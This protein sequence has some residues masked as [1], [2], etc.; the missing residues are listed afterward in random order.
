[1]AGMRTAAALAVLVAGSLL[2]RTGTLHAGYWIDEGIAVGIA[3]HDLADIPRT[4]RLDGSPPL[5]YLLLHGWMQL[6]GSGEE[7]TRALSL[8][9]ALV[10]VPVAWWA[11]CAVFDRRAGLLAAAGA[12]GCPFLT[13]YAQETRMYS[14]VVVLSLA[15]CASFAR[16]F[17]GDRRRHL[18]W[19]G[20]WLVLLLYTHTWGVFLAAG[21]GVTWLAL[22]RAGRVDGRD[23]ARLGA[24]VLLAY[25]P[26]LP[27]LAFQAAHTGAPWSER[28][29]LL[30]LLA[31][32]GA[33]FG[34][35]A[36]PPLLLAAGHAWR[37]AP[38]PEAVSVMAGLAAATVALAWIG[39]RIEP[40]WSPRYLAVAFGPALLVL[41]AV[42]SRGTRRTAALLALVA[43]TWLVGGPPAAKSNARAVA[44]RLTAELGPGDL[45]VSTQPEQVPVLYRYL[46]AGLVYLTP[47]GVVP[48]PRLT[49]WRDAFRQLRWGRAERVL[50]P[51]VDR[52]APG[53]RVVLVTPAAPRP[54]GPWARA[55]QARTREWRAAL[56]D[57]PRLRWIA[58][59]GLARSRGR[60][61]PVRAELFYVT[62]ARS[63]MRAPSTP[64]GRV[65]N[66]RPRASPSRP[67]QNASA[68]AGGA[69]RTSSDAWNATARSST[70]RRASHS[71][72]A[73]P[74]RA[75]RASRCASSRT[76]APRASS[77]SARKAGRPSGSRDMARRTSRL[78]TFPEPSQ[79][80][81]SGVSRRSRGMGDSST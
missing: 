74:N 56:R 13:Y 20:V 5:Y 31:V 9:F 32:P 55:V 81:F 42:L 29:S 69:W 62:S 26:W 64:A 44:A 48:D 47:L 34:Y 68:T 14:L 12:A 46:P 67:A 30:H 59:A 24:A 53:R 76:S 15:A 23:G 57:D 51:L 38:R 65:P 27:S 6:A 17:L 80:P 66:T 22:W 25:A 75:G 21:M 2:L 18:A 60:R 72:S 11:G 33:L 8:A 50:L 37:R 79:M 77:H 49:D 35:V 71:A 70:V 52:L 58:R 61:S 78:I 7:A 43:A 19:L 73:A 36:S 4:L 40:A 63:T 16:A 45:V 1:M 54:R 39:S 28:P 41:A 10:A 3:S